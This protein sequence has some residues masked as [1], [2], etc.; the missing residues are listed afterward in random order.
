LAESIGGLGNDIPATPL[1]QSTRPA[2]PFDVF[3]NP[4]APTQAPPPPSQFVAQAA[5]VQEAS[6]RPATPNDDVA[7]E[8][9]PEEGFGEFSKPAPPRKPKVSTGWLPLALAG[10]G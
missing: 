10:A 4:Q 8:D 2:S 5:P 3:G 6:R 1:P 9:M 7:E